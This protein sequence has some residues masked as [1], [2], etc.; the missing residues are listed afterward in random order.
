M[1]IE[2]IFVSRKWPELTLLAWVLLA[3][4]AAPAARADGD[5]SPYWQGGKL[6][7]YYDRKGN[8]D[9]QI[10]NMVWTPVVKGGYGVIVPESGAQETHYFGAFIRPLLAH[11]NEGDLIVGAQEIAQGDSNQTEVQGEYRLTSGWGFGGGFVDRKDSDMDVQ[12]AKL[13]YRNQWQDIRYILATQWQNFQQQDYAGGYVALYDKQWMATWGHDGEQWRTAFGYVAPDR[14][15][16]A[17]RP[18]LEV[19]YFDHSIGNVDGSK[20]IWITGSL[21]FRKG[22]L[23]HESRLGRAM[24]PTGVEMAN[25]IGYLGPNFNRRLTAWEVGDFANFRFIHKTLPDGKREQTLETAVYPAQLWG[26]E[27]WLDALFVGVGTTY[28]DPGEEAISG[29][30]GYRQRWGDFESST[31][32]Q[33]DFDRDETALFFILIHWL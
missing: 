16:Q 5:R 32:L 2:S 30:F 26:A 11:P 6:D 4:P 8:D 27:S 3:G 12:F 24:G 19:F 23:G 31:R 20:E 10:N 18:A 14:G 21:G 22:F 17:L 13:S 15:P 29:I 7:S 33:H 1:T 28:Y 25:P 9:F